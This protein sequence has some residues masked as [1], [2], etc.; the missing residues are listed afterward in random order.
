MDDGFF[1]FRGAKTIFS[2]AATWGA[3]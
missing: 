1:H 3:F 2:E